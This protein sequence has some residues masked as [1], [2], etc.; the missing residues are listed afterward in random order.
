VAWFPKVVVVTGLVVACTNV[1]LLSLDV[2]TQGLE[3]VATGLFPMQEMEFA[4][5]L[6][7]FILFFFIIPFT[8]IYY[9][10]YDDDEYKQSIVRQVY[11]LFSFLFFSFP[12]FLYFFF[13][14]FILSFNC[15][16]LLIFS[17]V[18]PS[19]GSSQFL[20]LWED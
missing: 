12:P 19:F 7:T 4:F 2:G 18:M 16:S 3:I 9:E 5:F 13:L 20:Q 17:Y 10:G 11:F 6:I 1:L 15:F 14:S 8:Y